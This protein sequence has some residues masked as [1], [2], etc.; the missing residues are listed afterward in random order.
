MKYINLHHKAIYSNKILI[1]SFFLF[2]VFQIHLV[3]ADCNTIPARGAQNNAT[4]A[5]FADGTI[6]EY[7]CGVGYTIVG[8]PVHRTCLGEN[9]WTEG[10][11]QYNCQLSKISTR[12]NILK[13][14]F[15]DKNEI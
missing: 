11:D 6:I 7:F 5:R 9:E 8:Q 13:S 10:P 1:F 15:G 14:L 4:T 12:T 3:S 2:S